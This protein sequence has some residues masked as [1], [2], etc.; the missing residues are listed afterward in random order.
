LYDGAFS[1]GGRAG[2]KITVRFE[3]NNQKVSGEYAYGLGAG[4]IQ[5]IVENNHLYYQW[6]EGTSYGQGLFKA[7]PDGNQFEGTW[8]YEQ[9]RDNGGRWMGKRK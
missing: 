8:G 5:G 3:R 7:S 9:S 1:S 2:V 4:K 6:R